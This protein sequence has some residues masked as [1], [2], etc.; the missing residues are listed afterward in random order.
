MSWSKSRPESPRVTIKRKSNQDPAFFM[1]KITF[2]PTKELVIHE[3]SEKRPDEFYTLMIQQA[4]GSGSRR[5]HP[6]RALGAR[7]C[8]YVRFLS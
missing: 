2:T 5:Y 4:S 3:I 7:S 8:L 1:V 6:E